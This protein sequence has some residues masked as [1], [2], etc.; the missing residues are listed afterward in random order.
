MRKS[1]QRGNRQPLVEPSRIAGGVVELD[2]ATLQAIAN[3]W[4]R[5][6]R[7]FQVTFGGVSMLPTIN[8]GQEV[9]LLCTSVL[10]TPGTVV[11]FIHRNQIAVH[12]LLASSR[13][14]QW[15]ITRGD[16]HVL[17]DPPVPASAVVGIVETEKAAPPPSII[18]KSVARCAAIL[19][20]FSPR[21]YQLCIFSAASL[22]NSLV[23]LLRTFR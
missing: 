22:R 11:A 5:D 2:G 20:N 12:R 17:P 23:R 16:A 21:L 4:K 19:I 6:Q 10:P 7:T 13:D 1:K 15:L 3:T 14:G 9:R 18:R 8:P